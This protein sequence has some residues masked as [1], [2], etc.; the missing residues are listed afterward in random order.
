MKEKNKCLSSY[1]V[2]LFYQVYK[3]VCDKVANEKQ[4]SL[5]S[6]SYSTDIY[7]ISDILSEK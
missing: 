2:I 6:L 7:P 5:V 4:N 1:P 3:I